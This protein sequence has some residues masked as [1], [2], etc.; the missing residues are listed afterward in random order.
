MDCTRTLRVACC[1]AG[2]VKLW[3]TKSTDCIVTFRLPTANPT[4]EV[5]IHTLMLLHKN[6]DHVVIC[7]RSPSVYLATYH[8]QVVKTFN[9]PKT[10]GGDF[11]H[12][13]LRPHGDRL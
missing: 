2:T 5:P 7:N 8:G 12:C 10:S 3:D 1:S 4:I 13:I 11:A 9:S 6:A